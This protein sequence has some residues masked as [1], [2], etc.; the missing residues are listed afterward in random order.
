MLIARRSL[1]NQRGTGKKKS[2]AESRRPKAQLPALPPGKRLCY[3]AAVRLC[4]L[5][6]GSGGNCLW[7]E[8]DGARVLVDAGLSAKETARRCHAAGL[9][10]RDLTGILLTHEHADHAG[11]AAVL[12]RKLGV[13]VY[14][15]RGTLG[16]LREAPPEELWR[17][18]EAGRPIALGPTFRALP[19][20]AEHDAREPVVYSLEERAP[21]GAQVR[22]AVITDVGHAPAPLAEAL[23]AHDAL[24]MEMNH[25]LRRLLDGPYPWSLKERVRSQHG[26]L[27]NAQGAA[28]LASV[29]HEHLR[30]VVLAHL[31]QENNT[32]DLA[33]AAAEKVLDRAGSRARLEVAAQFEPGEVMEISPRPRAAQRPR[34]LA[35]F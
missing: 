2:K 22:A 30:R 11:G 19:L 33:R 35:L 4:V 5:A 8:A 21:G 29:L 18:V 34:Q 32:P 20:H 9:E 26:H 15:T 6:S 13:P 31:S 17:I 14:A 1:G 23:S 7:A 27:S 28:L 3:S 25:D 10:L 12:A 24:V 16:A